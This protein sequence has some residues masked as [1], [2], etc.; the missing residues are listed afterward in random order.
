MQDN[1]GREI[2]NSATRA[3]S[4]AE[5]HCKQMRGLL[6]SWRSALRD[7][8]MK[9]ENLNCS[10]SQ[11]VNSR[12]RQ[13]KDLAAVCVVTLLVKD[14]ALQV[15]S[16]LQKVVCNLTQCSMHFLS[17]VL[18]SKYLIFLH[19]TAAFQGPFKTFWTQCKDQ[20]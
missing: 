16:G 15:T 9:S 11:P 4:C 2:A 10:E 19:S 6:R 17:P 3:P 8:C 12:L 7:T 14:N 18:N 1:I 5:K 13:T 20:F